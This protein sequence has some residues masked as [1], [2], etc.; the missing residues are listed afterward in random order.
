[1]SAYYEKDEK[2][3]YWVLKK[4]IYEFVHINHPVYGWEKDCFATTDEENPKIVPRVR[5]YRKIGKIVSFFYHAYKS[6][7]VVKIQSRIKR[8]HID[9]SI[10]RIQKWLSSNE[11]NFK[12]HPIFSNKPPLSSLVSKIVYGC[13]H[14]LHMWSMSVTKDGVEYNYIL[15]LLDVFSRFLKLRQRFQRSTDASKRDIR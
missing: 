1:M 9:I 8:L 7:G 5:Y 6:K 14:M 3:T 2:K 10:K 13:N 12:I 4:G 11:N 15:S